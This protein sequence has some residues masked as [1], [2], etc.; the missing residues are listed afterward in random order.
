M[1][2]IESTITQKII[3][4]NIQ[5]TNIKESTIKLNIIPKLKTSTTPTIKIA[6]KK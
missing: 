1:S 5:L 4:E 6:I 2:F 3:I